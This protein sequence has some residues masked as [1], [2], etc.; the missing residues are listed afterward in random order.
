MNRPLIGNSAISNHQV[1]EKFAHEDFKTQ[2]DDDNE[3]T[4]LVDGHGNVAFS[5][6]T[7][8]LCQVKLVGLG[9]VLHQLGERQEHHK[10][11]EA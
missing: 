1:A 10:E 9:G 3:E 2:G 8:K 6:G 11:V 4:N 7:R 5:G